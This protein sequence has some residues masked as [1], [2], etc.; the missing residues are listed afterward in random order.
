LV[1]LNLKD[2][3]DGVNEQIGDETF[4]GVL[5]DVARRRRQGLRAGAERGEMADVT[6]GRGGEE[7]LGLE[8][9]GVGGRESEESGLERLES[10]RGRGTGETG[11]AV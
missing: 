4:E 2:G 9:M 3:E 7:M 1:S 11:D 8:E 5:V 6:G 10:C